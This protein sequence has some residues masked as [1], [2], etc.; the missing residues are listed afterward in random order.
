MLLRPLLATFV[1]GCALGAGATFLASRRSAP[2]PEAVKAISPKL[3]PRPEAPVMV[4]E[5]PDDLSLQEIY[6]RVSFFS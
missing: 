3:T 2:E 1:L 4:G 6:E 5:M